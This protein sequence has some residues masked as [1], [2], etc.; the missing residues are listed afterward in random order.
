MLYGY[1]QSN[2]AHTLFFKHQRGK[3]VILSVYVDY[4]VITSNDDGIACLKDMLA[5]SFEV[6]DL[7]FLHYF[8]G[9]EVAYGSQGFYLS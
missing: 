7:G 1:Q 9:I 3:I 5:K 6:K 8:L 4:I 2:A